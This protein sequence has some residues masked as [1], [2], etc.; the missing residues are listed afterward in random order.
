MNPDLE[1]GERS[2][3]GACGAHHKSFCNKAVALLLFL[4]V[5]TLSQR[6]V[7]QDDLTLSIL[8]QPKHTLQP[9]TVQQFQPVQTVSPCGKL[10]ESCEEFCVPWNSH[11]FGMLGDC[12]H[13][14]KIEPD[15][16]HVN[17]SEGKFFDEFRKTVDCGK[18]WSSPHM[19]VPGEHGH[20]P[21]LSDLPKEL[22]DLYSYGGKVKMTEWYLDQ[23]YYGTNSTDSSS[24]MVHHWKRK[25]IQDWIQQARAKTLSGNYGIGET[26]CL[27]AGLDDA[28][29]KGKSVLVIGSE[30]PWVEAL[31]L[32]K[33]AAKVTTLE[34]ANLTSSHPLVDTVT[35]A[36]LA[37]LISEG[38]APSF[39][40]VVTFSSVEH[41]GLGR[42]GDALNPFGDLITMARAWCLA[43]PNADLVIGVMVGGSGQSNIRFN[44]ARWY[45]AVS[46]AQLFANWQQ[47]TRHHCGQSVYTLKKLP[48]EGVPQA[49]PVKQVT[50]QQFQPVQTVSPCGKLCESCE[51]FCVPW[52]SHFFGMLGDCGH[53][54][55]VEP[56]G[57]HVNK[58]K[59]KFF[60]EFRKTVDCGKIWSSPHMDV[61][62]EHGHP[63]RLSDLP[64][65][66]VDLYSYSGKVKLFKWYWDQKY[67]GT[68]S[69]NLSHMVHHWKRK[70]IQ[71][72]IQ[73]ARAKTLSGNYG[74][75]ETNCLAAGL[76]DADLK[77]KSVL[78]IG[79]ENPWVE[80]LCLSKGA[81]KVTTLE[82]ANLT[83]SHPLVD[84]VTPATLASL[85]SEGKAPSFD[86]VVTFSS[87]EHS[88][89]GRYGDALNPFGDL[90]TMARAW[91]L[92]KPNADLVIGVMVG[93]SGQSKIRFNA[94]REYGAVSY[95][96][97]FANWQ[98]MTRHR[99][100]QSVYTL[101][102]L[103][104]E[105]VPQ[106]LPV[107]Q[108]TVQQF[109]PVQT[110]SPCG[111]LCESCEEFCVPWN[112]HFFGMLGDCGHVCKV[113]PDGHHVNK[114]K[115]KFFDEFRKTVD[116]G[117]IW[118]SP[119][120]DVPG[121]HGH[122]PRLS[123]LPKELVDL[124]S[125]SGKV[126]LFE[127][128]WDQKYYGTTS[129][130]LSHMVHHWKR[131]TIQDWIQKARAKTL[132]GNYGI[133]E[134]NC[135]AAGLDD[136]DL[137]GKSVLVIG[138]ENPWVEA[139]CLS[140]GAAKVTTLEYANLTSS[141]PLVDTVTPATLASLVSEG[142]APSFDAV[143]TF[144][145]VEHS[146]LGRY[147]DALNPFGD[148]ITMARAWCLAKPN[149][150]LVIGVMVGGSGQSTIRF[151]A[152]REYGAVSY[153]QLFANWQ[154][155]TRHRCGQSVYTLKKL[156]A[157]GVPQALPVKQVTVQQFQPVQ[158]VSPC[159]KLCESCE[160]FC[161]PWNSHFFGM[162]GDC[163]HVCKVEPDGH[164]VNKSK[165]KFFD[166][167]RKTVDCGKIWSSPHMDVPGEHGHP[168]R[169]S[170]LPKELVDLY[171][172]SGKVKLFKWYWDQKYYGTTSTNLSHMVHH[173]KRK[174]IQDWIQKARAKTLSGNY[175]IG[176]TNCLAAG[177][178]DADLKGKSVLV[179]GSENPWVEALCLSKGAAKVTTLEYA[180]LTSSHP[181]VDTV[182]PA[183][184]A[185]L[186]SE[187]KAPS[188]D[189]VVTFSSVEHSGLG[190]YGDALNPF[191]D[192]ITM[193]RAWCLA[194]P[195]ADLVIGVMVG[196]S[197]QSKIRFNAHREYGAV[198]Y[199]QL[200][201]NWQQMTRHHCGQ[202]VYTLKKLDVF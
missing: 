176:E 8:T 59:G 155:M 21:R 2:A 58:S 191:G 115:G 169:L 35:P 89:L 103:P 77:G 151:N 109:Q 177:L 10:C 55:K 18:I 192:L 50:V 9:V 156:P 23:K 172:Y 164:H 129:T 5:L 174:T 190:R 63:P 187:G 110:V 78:V 104:A 168:P 116:C 195:N 157:E 186:V 45:G 150:D 41:S 113:E 125:Y 82:Y 146:G 188:F 143:V 202:S 44:A 132:S 36:T 194:K 166:E 53:V 142:K 85:I 16:H 108:V 185:S 64:K 12:G 184:L 122:P 46:Y 131:K 158:T 167:F 201:A 170:D 136:A 87:V 182:T 3:H 183:T 98:Q 92:A 73:K 140:K 76:D 97:L 81:A 101:K 149:A 72:W 30:N 100:G 111:K 180:N 31:C 32:S 67:Y 17:K 7:W 96:Q 37:S 147:G 179:I 171:S 189:A 153:A 52:N 66:L 154:Q 61:P 120:M 48:G 11:F 199:A 128:Y 196:G 60:D 75:G 70:T 51:E 86:A 25:T 130:N 84:T 24:H 112:S 29:L 198:S 43:K 133:G 28:D 34:Y 83:S 68:T 80:A 94:H 93:G 145:S 49:L 15:G 71:D 79:S 26:N 138:S 141:H 91:C 178:D 127:W 20:P 22:V 6:G 165:G 119:H 62:G 124:Y 193:A 95:A 123:D 57:H 126:K 144:S 38:K 1:I 42:Y 114:S 160:E 118:S 14:C 106:A 74:I 65:E 175:G 148:L 152:H 13:V 139:L 121:E 90:I 181:L 47:M 134:T 39:D 163:G 197:G 162:L 88:G 117:K 137:K 27:A 200:F 102:K 173:W 135:L 99:C 4:L 107:K 161:V 40:A 19:D 105:G 69:T 159:G 33:G 54:C 56:D